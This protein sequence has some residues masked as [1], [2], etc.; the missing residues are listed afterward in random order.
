M[1]SVFIQWSVNTHTH[2]QT[3]KGWGS[4]KRHETVCS[5]LKTHN[6]NNDNRRQGGER[7]TH[8]RGRFSTCFFSA[9]IFLYRIP[10][11]PLTLLGLTALCRFSIHLSL[12]AAERHAKHLVPDAVVTWGYIASGKFISH[13]HLS[14]WNRRCQEKAKIKQTNKSKKKQKTKQNTVLHSHLSLASFSAN[15]KQ[16]WKLPQLINKNSLHIWSRA[17]RCCLLTSKQYSWPRMLE[18][19]GLMMASSSRVRSSAS[20][21]LL[22][23]SKDSWEWDSL[24]LCIKRVLGSSEGDSC[25]QRGG[26]RRPDTQFRTRN[27][28]WEQTYF[29]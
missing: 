27:N 28:I 21:A 24:K 8:K 17:T 20:A 29:W 11:S 9:T 7:A 19:T 10:F 4:H 16:W 22:G 26:D 12:S 23:D 14:L 18:W 25:G 5:D 2:T 6:N 3:H 15:G 13:S 1:V